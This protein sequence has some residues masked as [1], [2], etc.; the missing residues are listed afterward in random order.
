M[1]AGLRKRLIAGTSAALAAIL[2]V[3]L[4][5]V[6]AVSFYTSWRQTNESLALLAGEGMQSDSPARMRENLPGVAAS[7]L[8][9]VSNCCM[10]RLR[11]D[12]SLYE[13]KSENTQRF[14]DALVLRI[15][16][17]IKSTGKERGR[18]GNWAFQIEKAARGDRIAVIDVSAELE[19]AANLLRITL[20][21]GLLFWLILSAMAALLIVRLLRPV[22]EAFARQQRFVWDAS[23]ELKT[24]LAVISANAQVLARELGENEALGYIVDEVDRTGALVQSLLT[25]ARMDAGKTAGETH[26]FDL[27]KSLLGA[28]L[29]MESLAFEAGHTL[30]LKICEG[31]RFT[32]NEAMIQELA[33]ILLS[34]AIQYAQR[35][36]RITVSLQAK[37]AARVLTVHNTGSYID[38]KTRAHVFERF[39]RGEASHNRET[40][41]SG[42][43]LSIAKRIVDLHG[44][45]IRVRSSMEEGTAFVI[46]LMER[47]A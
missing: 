37:G 39:Y 29:P 12:G 3:M 20:A 1:I 28:M 18:A 33:V 47:R 36:S 26:A 42:L 46:T 8:Y 17:E 40:G 27:G 16:E 10:I 22:E 23:H 38:P 24:P 5:V 44:G 6:N 7:S 34:N 25:L 2:L 35:G 11:R 30:E 19:Y 41:G 15:L 21:V 31:V 45:T 4:V 14:D 9:R 32:G 43:G 13:W